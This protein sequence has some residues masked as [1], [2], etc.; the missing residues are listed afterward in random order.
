MTHRGWSRVSIWEVSQVEP[1]A[2]RSSGVKTWSF[3]SRAIG[4]HWRTSC[5]EVSDITEFFAEPSLA[6]LWLTGRA[7]ASRGAVAVIGCLGKR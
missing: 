6:A 3:V 7:D 4:S 5:Q 2:A 1:A